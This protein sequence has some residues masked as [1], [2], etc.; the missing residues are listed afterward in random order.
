[1][2][3]S[4]LIT[5]AGRGIGAAIAQALAAQGARVL[6]N[7]LDAAPAQA[8]ADAITAAGGT[9][10]AFAGNVCEPDFG[11]RA[12]AACME[13][14]G[15]LD[16]L[17][18]NAGY[19]WDGALH[20]MSDAQWAA[21]LDVHLTAPF[22]LLRAAYPVLKA[23]HQRDQEAGRVVHRK[24]V[25]VSSIV[26]LGG[27]AGQANYAAAK[28]GVV[29]L[30]KSLAKEWGRLAVNVN[31]V[32]YG[33]IETRLTQSRNESA[34]VR[35]G[36]QEVA[37][38]VNPELLRALAAQIPLGRAGSVEEAAGAVL[39]FCGAGSDYV[40]GQVLVCGGGMTLG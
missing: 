15:S 31:C 36:G 35:V 12:V 1:M 28:A 29:G 32:A 21:M 11:E 5:G 25:N 6:V 30:T 38:G 2:G 10:R 39:M 13:G 16:I 4:A 27:N 20:K 23:Q 40:S 7:D 24:V 22:R 17:V 34:T 26:G 9:A 37:I 14:F 18:N 33:H 19:T 8:V 3:R